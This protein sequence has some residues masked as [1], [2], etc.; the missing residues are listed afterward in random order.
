MVH[1][2]TA[3]CDKVTQGAKETHGILHISAMGGAENVL[4]SEIFVAFRVIA[5][6]VWSSKIRNDAA[7]R[8]PRY[9]LERCGGNHRLVDVLFLW[10]AS[11]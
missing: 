8:V 7:G 5:K 2:S 3:C 1:A 11:G 4:R 10:C 6:R 9:T